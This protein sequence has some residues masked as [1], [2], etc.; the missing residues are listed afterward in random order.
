MGSESKGDEVV[1]KHVGGKQSIV[2]VAPG[3]TKIDKHYSSVNITNGDSITFYCDGINWYIKS[4]YKNI[5]GDIPGFFYSN[6]PIVDDS[7][8]Y[9][10]SPNLSNIV[11][12]IDIAASSQKV[13]VHTTNNFKSANVKADDGVAGSNWFI[14]EITGN[15]GANLTSGIDGQEITVYQTEPGTGGVIRFVTND[16]RASTL[17]VTTTK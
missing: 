1:V 15:I 7:R 16:G 4:H 14:N 9:F 2:I 10:G 6:D 13:Y 8:I 11:T 5:F 3:V 12:S 17:T